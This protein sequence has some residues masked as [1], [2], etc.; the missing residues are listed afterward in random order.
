LQ[1]GAGSRFRYSDVG[2]IGLGQLV[3]KLSGETLD[4]LTRRHIFEPLA[5][6]DTAFKPTGRLADR[7]VPTERC[8]GR[9]IRGEVHDP[10]AYLLGGVAGH[11]GLF[12]TADDLAVFCQMILNHGDY[13]GVRI[14][15]P[16]G[17]ARMTE[18]RP[19]GGNATDGNARGL[20]W[21]IVKAY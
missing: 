13:H 1:S 4:I 9:W 6:R 19:S 15:S 11:A 20:G 14:L 3:E 8:D 5:M 17:I 7:A 12:S 18:T 21:D 16:M 10:R 2:Y